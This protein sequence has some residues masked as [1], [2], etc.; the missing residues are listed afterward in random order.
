MASAVV[1]GRVMRQR[2]DTELDAVCHGAEVARGSN[3]VPADRAQTMP[4][5]TRATKAQARRWAAC[6]ALLFGLLAQED[7]PWFTAANLAAAGEQAHQL[8]TSCTH[9]RERLS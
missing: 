6:A 4:L 3:G 9:S 8:T 2:R 5:A 1:I 7:L